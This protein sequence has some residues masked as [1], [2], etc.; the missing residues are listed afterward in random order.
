MLLKS[1]REDAASADRLL[2]LDVHEVLDAKSVDPSARPTLLLQSQR[3]T[4][5]GKQ[6]ALGSRET[7]RREYRNLDKIAKGNSESLY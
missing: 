2:A 1:L 5:G 3:G 7:S 4:S 6:K